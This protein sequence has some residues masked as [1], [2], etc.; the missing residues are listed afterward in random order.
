MPYQQSNLVSE[1]IA[2]FDAETQ[3][4]LN[5]VRNAIQA[6]FPHTIEDISYGIPTYR[7][8]PG[9]RGLVHFGAAGGHIG[10]YGIFDVRNNASIHEKM[11]KYRTGRG[12][13]Q[14]KNTEPL[15]MA[16]IRQILTFHKAHIETFTVTS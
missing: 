5:L 16:D 15:P 12:T 8:A 9:K 11:Q 6:T 2:R 7:P 10:I 3:R 14:F 1:Y 13:L 4:R